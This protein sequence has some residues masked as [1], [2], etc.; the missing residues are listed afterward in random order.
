MQNFL[1][2]IQAFLD[3]LC[4]NRES[5]ESVLWDNTILMLARDLKK[6]YKMHW[7]HLVCHKHICTSTQLRYEKKQILF[8]Y[9]IHKHPAATVLGGLLV[10]Y[11]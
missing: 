8:D 4:M 3:N 7:M 9:E 11:F 2:I 1:Y 10:F 5:L 6:I